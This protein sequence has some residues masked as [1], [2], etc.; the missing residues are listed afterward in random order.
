MY[1]V[2]VVVERDNGVTFL[3][4]LMVMWVIMSGT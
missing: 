2:L 1:I 4:F 3:L